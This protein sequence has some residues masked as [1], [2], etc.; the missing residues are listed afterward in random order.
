MRFNILI[1]T[2]L[3]IFL[4]INHIDATNNIKTYCPA[5]IVTNFTPSTGPENTLITISGSNFLDVALVQM[6]GEDLSFNIISDTELTVFAPD[7]LIGSSTQ[8]ALISSGGCFGISTQMFTLIEPDCDAFGNNE[9]YISEVY[10]SDG[11]S[12][13]VFELYNPTNVIVDLSTVYEIE[14]YGNIGD[15]TP[16]NTIPLAGFIDPFDTFIIEMGSTGNTCSGLLPNI[17]LAAGI[18]END[19]IRLLK[20]AVVIDVIYTDDE[21]GYTFIRNSD[22]VAPSTT[23]DINEWTLFE[24]EDCSDLRMHTEDTITPNI[25]Q[26]VSQTICENG[27]TSFNVSVD[28]GTYTYQWKTLDGAGNWIN[29]S[30]DANYSGATT[31]TLTINNA[32][33]NFNNNQYYCEITATG[34]DLLSI[35]IQ[36]Q[37]LSAEV[38]TITNQ[39]VC[40]DFTLPPLTNGNYFSASG[41]NG[42]SFSA[43][44]VISTTQTIFIYNELGTPPNICSSETSFL[45]TVSGTPLVDTITDQDVCT[46]FTLPTLTNGSYFSASGGNGSMFNAGDVISTTQTIFIYNVVGTAPDTCSNETSFTITVSGTPLVDTIADQNVCTDFTLP[47]LTNG[48]YFA[49]T[50]GN[51]TMFNVGDVISTTQTIFIYNEVGTSPDICSNESSFTIT[52]VGTPLVDTIA[53]QNVCTDFTLPALTNGSYFA[54]TGGNGTTFSAGE[55]ITSTQTI[56]I[57]NEV[58]IAP[59]NCSNESS[60]TITV[61]GAPLVDTIPD[62][63]VCSDFTLPTLTNGSYFSNSG[64]TGT[65]FNA[66]DVIT[67]TQTIFIFN[68]IGTAPDTCSNESSFTITVSTTPLVD[69]VTDQNVCGDFTLPALTNG[70]YFSASGGNGTSFN[71]GDVISTTQTI[72]IYN[73]VG[74]APDTCSNETSFTV[75]VTGLP[76]V[77]T[78]SDQSVCSD[79]TLPALTNG[80]YFSA[81]GGNGTTFNA[82]DVISS[83]QTIF[84]YNEVGSAPNNCSNETS[85]IITIS[86][87]P[88]V[89]MI[90]DQNVCND[91]TLP[92]L[93]NGSYFSASGGN[94]TSFN[95]G[96]IITTTQ[97]IFIY[98]EIGTAPDICTNESS[99]S[100]MISGTPLVDTIVDQT[101]CNEF[102]LPTLTN[103]N[104]FSASGGN[105]TTFNAGDVISTTQTIFIYNEIAPDTC[106]NETSFT[107]SI[108]TSTDFS[109][110]ESN[111]DILNGTLTVNM[112]EIL[113]F[114]YALTNLNFQ[115]SNVFSNLP[116]GSYILYVREIGGCITKQISFVINVDLFIPQYFTPNGDTFKDTWK[117]IDKNNIVKDIFIFDRYGK[118]LKHIIGNSVFWDGTFNGKALGSNDF[119][120]LI[121]LKTGKQLK[122]HFTLKR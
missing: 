112:T 91:F 82:G 22:A 7:G 118:L 35:A 6:Q 109:L 116:V 55:V 79:F 48:S 73:E 85:F 92:T 80:N 39:N 54:A 62:E 52:I 29:I 32:P 9:I 30:N 51:G 64:G 67:S 101:V 122:G 21:I 16:S 90:A 57:Y 50:G 76:L 33:L 69:T 86:T 42:A 84:I 70:N 107:I 75:T 115:T 56:F 12:Y 81:S 3:Y 121:N 27:S 40:T 89:D 46:D 78:I 17:T 96:D 2:I 71:A 31:T 63:S 41:G 19:E 88:S 59:N 58:G 113:N 98:N 117:I 93:T 68:E 95:A 103:G 66:G 1:L 111:I 108:G 102:I 4:P 100:I 11:G 13:G 18:N 28:T 99:F 36:L 47:A 104:Y 77:D 65:T 74:T 10:D 23:F 25:T 26:P 38:D 106:S 97:T 61:S 83:T 43:G 24:I 120:Y 8:I 60:F 34:C 94:G 72:F 44:D 119:W 20:N 110:S 114:E 87:I 105:G 5:P 15:A 49:A 45:I 37:V 14:R 53:D